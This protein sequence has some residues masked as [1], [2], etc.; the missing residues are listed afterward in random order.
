MKKYYKTLG[1]DDNADLKQIKKA[2][3]KMASMYH[4]DKPGGNEE[5]FKEISNA[6]EILT[7]KS[8]FIDPNNNTFF[9]GEW[10]SFAQVFNDTYNQDRRGRNVY[11][12]LYITLEEAYTGVNKTIGSGFGHQV[13][14][15]KGIKENQKIILDGHGQRGGN[16][17]G[18]LDGNLIITIKFTP[19]AKFE[20]T[21]KGLHFL[22][23]IDLY[24]AILGGVQIVNLFGKVIKYNLPKFTQQ[25]QTFRLKGKGFPI[26]NRENEFDDLYIAI[27]V[28]LPTKFSDEQLKLIKNLKSLSEKK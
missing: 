7:K 3:R 22:E 17:D 11:Y 23:H 2:Y 9:D 15:P 27:V 13:E 14:V 20:R 8:E 18:S 16:E 5:K 6:Y 19:H 25:G 4:P 26:M 28:D 12:T 1:L 10:S 24:T 21:D